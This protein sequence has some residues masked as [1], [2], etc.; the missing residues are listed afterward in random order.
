MQ[1]NIQDAI[2]IGKANKSALRICLKLELPYVLVLV[3][4]SF[5]FRFVSFPG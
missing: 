3:L 4:V 1:T 5:C 2:E